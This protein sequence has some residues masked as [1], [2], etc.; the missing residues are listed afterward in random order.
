MAQFLLIRNLQQE[1][2]N[3]RKTQPTRA[4]LQRGSDGLPCYRVQATPIFGGVK[5]TNEV[6]KASSR[7]NIMA[8]LNW[9]TRSLDAVPFVSAWE[10]AS[11][12]FLWALASPC[13]TSQCCPR[14]MVFKP[15]CR[16]LWGNRERKT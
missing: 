16:I 9:E 1:Q 2:G 14:I 6:R 4:K 10:L 5:K 11:S 13:V 8:T 7:S 3:K 15:S 12:A